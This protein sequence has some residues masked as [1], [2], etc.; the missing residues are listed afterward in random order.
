MEDPAFPAELE[1]EIFETTAVLYPSTIL[2]LLLVARRIL[3]WI[4]PFLYT[5]VRTD[6]K[7]MHSAVERAIKTKP[8]SFFTRSVR[9]IYLGPYK[10]DGPLLV[11]MCPNLI[12]LA[13]IRPRG[14]PVLLA[15][16]HSFRNIQRWSGSLVDL[17]DA[18]DAVDL[19][20][21]VFKT[22]THMDVFDDLE[23]K[24]RYSSKLCASLA[25]LPALTHLCLN[26]TAEPRPIRNFLQHCAGLQVLVIMWSKPLPAKAMLGALR[27][28]GITDVRYVVAVCNGYWDDW[29]VG[30][31][32][33]VDFWVAAEDLI[34]RKRSGEIE[35]N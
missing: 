7:G 31:R 17:F 2:T 32:G 9:H 12:S 23:S 27:E 22:V 4:E 14:Q 5:V 3:V 10:F 30:A 6:I 1:R 15:A 8:D 18:A 21:P 11:R 33:G 20:L 16:I 28:A 34:A 35:G 29:E 25:A 13:Y 24:N 26:R 19:S